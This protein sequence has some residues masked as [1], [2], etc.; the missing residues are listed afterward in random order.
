MDIEGAARRIEGVVERTALVPFASGDE[1]VELR[2][3]LE[4]LQSTGSF[5]A[6]GAWN[7]VSQLSPEQRSKGVVTVSSGNHGKALSWAAARAGI[8]ACV[9]MPADAYP[10]KIEACRSFGAEVVLAPSRDD[11]DRICAERV[12]AGAVLIHPFD[13]LKTIEGPATLGLEIADDWPEVEA[14][15]V[16]LG[17]G[18]LVSGIALALEG[19]LPRTSCIGV[20]P[21][22][23]AKMTRAIAAGR[24]VRLSEVT[25]KVQGLCPLQAGRITHEICSRRVTVLTLDDETILAGQRT[26]VRDGGW[27]VE[28]A[29]AAAAALVLARALPADLLR[30]RSALD[31]VRVAAV[32]SGG[33][34]DPAQLAAVR[35]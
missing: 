3:K 24:P 1:R 12:A 9:V 13:D 19:R 18:G 23:A 22:G 5:K 17:G 25:T 14:V 35:A 26:L 8:R 28:P 29:G 15:V 21:A 6:R 20:E 7:Q 30:G 4:C 27:V 33:N 34:P 16:P 2:L 10:N 32:V 31:R 11:A